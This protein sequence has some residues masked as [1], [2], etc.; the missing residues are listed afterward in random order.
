[1]RIREALERLDPLPSKA[2][3]DTIAER[4]RQARA[5]LY[6]RV[7]ELRS[8]DEWRRWA[9]VGVQEQL[10]ARTEALLDL[11]DPAEA[12]RQLRE[13]RQQWKQSADVPRER[14]QALWNRFKAAH[15]R[16]REKL[17]DYFAQQEAERAEV[18]TRRAAL[19]AE[20]EGLAA[21]TDWGRTA[22]RVGELQAEWKAMG[23]V[24]GSES[25]QMWERF[26]RA[27]D[28]FFTRRKQD[29]HQRKESW[30]AN[31]ARKEALCAQAETLAESVLKDGA[32]PTPGDWAAAAAA[33]KRLQAEWKTIGAVR[34]SKSDAVWQRFR[35]AC[36]RFF[37][38]YKQ[39]DQLVVQA[40]V[41]DRE[42]VCAELE[43][44]ADE[45]T[46]PP[47]LIERIRALRAKWQHGAVL[48]RPAMERLQERFHAALLRLA[49]AHPD[50]LRK[51]ELDPEGN[52]RRME[53]LCERVE[54]L[55]GSIPTPVGVGTSSADALAAR[56]REALA[57]NTIGGRVDEESKWRAALDDVR[58]AQAAWSRV[59]PVPSD[60]ARPLAAR[61]KAAC[62]R[63][64]EQR[65]ARR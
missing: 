56:L 1:M 26:R 2:D 59:G 11:D 32:P 24:P 8:A 6:P 17:K 37:E 44:L 16:V 65:R 61:F 41:A 25:R 19:V 15:D 13:I 7:Q 53:Q 33:L 31:L 28:H 27:C 22:K 9:N 3:R 52:R 12:A 34:R 62:D 30:A 36:D 42:A 49:T 14:A 50:R 54:K 20:A 39:R 58:Q 29:L 40:A 64:F 46:P 18:I 48:T 4:L 47:D 23:P 43:A 35:S 51:T 57:A 45:P 38:R 55:V 63:F 21:S 5:A 10:C 60:V